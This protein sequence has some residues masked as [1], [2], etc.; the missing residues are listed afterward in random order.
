MTLIVKYGW[1]LAI[2]LVVMGLSAGFVSQLWVPVPLGMIAAGVFIFSLWLI[3]Q[4][5]VGGGFGGERLTETSTNIVISALSFLV[6]LAMINFIALR[7][8]VRV[9]LTEND[10]FTLAPESQQLMQSLTKP[11]KLWIFDDRP[12]IPADLELLNN[13]RRLSPDNFNFEYANPYEQ[14][15]LAL[16][17]QVKDTGETY[18]TSNDGEKRAFVQSIKNRPLSESRLTNAIAEILA[19]RTFKVSFLTGHGE[20]P[21]QPGRGAISRAISTLEE[22]N[23]TTAELS[24]VAASGSDLPPTADTG[25]GDQ[26]STAA[27]REGATEEPDTPVLPVSPSP[28]VPE[29]TAVVAIVGPRRPL[30]ETTISAL[31]SYLDQGG[32]LFLAL[33]YG[34]ENGLDSLLAEWGI[35]LDKRLAIDESGTG[36]F[37]GLGSATPVITKYH[38]DNPSGRDGAHPIVRDFTESFS[39]YRF[40]RPVIIQEKSGITA[41][42]LL[43]TNEPSW[44]E[45][46]P[47]TENLKFD[48]G[49]DLPGPLTLGV[50]LVRTGDTGVGANGIRPYRAAGEQGGP[51]SPNPPVTPSPSPP[52]SPSPSPPVSP[53]EARMVVIGNSDFISDGRF[54]LQLNGD[55][56]LNSIAW[57]SK[58]NEDILSIRPKETTNR[59]IQMSPMQ[60]RLVEITAWG[61]LPLLGLL[62]S[63]IFWIQKR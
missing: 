36:S 50:A 5:T 60:S 4:E 48:E 58:Q 19:E 1:V 11:V 25:P 20:R 53:S 61:V 6:I 26:G 47:Q 24:L 39:F 2:M 32:S 29:D 8:V 23:F 55:V 42:P 16:K 21:L 18:L 13:Y 52:V 37:L 63:A 22:K 43:I 51:S 10:R 56:F 28:V 44:G 3:L 15:S 40:A 12:P 30:S 35:T 46:E 54:E 27:P 38:V 57:L 49:K 41:T 9:D 45:S 62:L 7:Y 14:D 31:K 33:D 59:R 17:F 34:L